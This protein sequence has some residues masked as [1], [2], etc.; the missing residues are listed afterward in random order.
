MGKK[1]DLLITI[2]PVD[3]PELVQEMLISVENKI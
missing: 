3:M 2:D 1:G